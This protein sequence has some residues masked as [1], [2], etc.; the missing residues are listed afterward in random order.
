MDINELLR[1][2]IAEARAIK[3]PVSDKISPQVVINRRAKTRL[4]C[5]KKTDGGFVIELSERVLDAGEAACKAVLAHEILHSCYGC[6]NH[7]IRWKSYA[8]RMSEAYGYD[9]NRTTKS[10]EIGV[11]RDYPVRYRFQ[12]D[13][14]GAVIERMRKSAF[15]ENYKRYR[16]R[17]GGRLQKVD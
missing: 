8:A 12:C 15:V 10:D 3:I 13:S 6:M 1:Q 9:I 2:V 7:G 16:C 14:C 17:C 5:C 11:E 4:G